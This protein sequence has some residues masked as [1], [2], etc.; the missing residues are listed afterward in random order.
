LHG[1]RHKSSVAKSDDDQTSIQ[2]QLIEDVLGHQRKQRVSPLKVE[3]LPISLHAKA[4]FAEDHS[5]KI[6]HVTNMKK[7]KDEAQVAYEAA[8][9]NKHEA[10]AKAAAAKRLLAQLQP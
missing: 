9:E 1:K 6:K 2:A 7:S 5:E 10:E 4:E 8:L 3:S